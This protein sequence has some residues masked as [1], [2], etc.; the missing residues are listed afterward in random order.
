MPGTTALGALEWELE[1]TVGRIGAYKRMAGQSDCPYTRAD[2]E[3]LACAEVIEAEALR[4][5]I[6]AFLKEM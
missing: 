3:A 4:R 2:F 1:L 5:S 6:R